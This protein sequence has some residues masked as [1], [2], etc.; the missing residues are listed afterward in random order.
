MKNS[1][2]AILS[3]TELND[4]TNTHLIWQKLLC[5]CTYSI[6]WHRF[7]ELVSITF[8]SPIESIRNSNVFGWNGK[9]SALSLSINNY[10][11]EGCKI[12]DSS[13]TAHVASHTGLISR[14]RY[15]VFLLASLVL[16]LSHTAPDGYNHLLERLAVQLI[17]SWAVT[18]QWS[19]LLDG[20]IRFPPGNPPAAETRTYWDWSLWNM[21]HYSKKIITA[22]FIQ[23]NMLPVWSSIKHYLY[24]W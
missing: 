22:S 24:K 21:S 10:V 13:V 9:S 14:W 20:K 1:H 7:Q 4:C 17:D 16:I 15:S 11:P 19:R 23:P 8:L 3:T 5:C 18:T 12:S 2:L 6:I